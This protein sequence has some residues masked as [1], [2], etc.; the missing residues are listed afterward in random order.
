MKDHQIYWTKMDHSLSL[1]FQSCSSRT[2]AWQLIRTM[3]SKSLELIMLQ[4]NKAMKK[5]IRASHCNY[6]AMLRNQKSLLGNTV[7]HIPNCHTRWGILSVNLAVFSLQSDKQADEWGGV[8]WNI[9]ARLLLP[10]NKVSKSI[11]NKTF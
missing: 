8:R 5:S 3:C 4:Y 11:K 7:H 6:I 1:I 2:A 9:H 10:K